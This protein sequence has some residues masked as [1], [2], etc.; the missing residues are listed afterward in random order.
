MVAKRNPF[1]PNSPVSPGMFV[2][3]IDEVLA[4]EQALVQTRAGQPKHFMLTGE[5]G[6]GKTSLLNYLRWV[7]QGDINLES[8]RFR[9][10]V[11]DL[12]IEKGTTPDTFARKIERGLTYELG[13]TE[14]ARDFLKKT[15]NF[16]K[17]VEAYGVSVRDEKSVANPEDI[18]EE[19]A[20][21]LASTVNRICGEPDEDDLFGERYDG[22]LFCI[23][24]ADNASNELQLG[25]VLKLLTER[26]Q[27]RGCERVLIGLAGLQDL[28]EVLRESHPSVLR[29]F[30]EISLQRLSAD[31][32]GKVIDR[33]IDDANLNN[34][35][36]ISIDS[37]AR[38]LLIQ[39]SE[40]YPHF[41][42]QFGYCAFA[43]DT[44]GIIDKDDV[45]RGGFGSRGAL[46]L[47]GDRYYRDDFYNRIQ[48]ESCRQVLR[49]MAD[50]LDEWI[51]KEEIRKR[52]KGQAAT[53]SNALKALRDRHIILSKEGTRGVY[54]LQHKGFGLWIKLYTRDDEVKSELDLPV[55]EA[56][57]KGDG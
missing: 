15:W 57:G 29:V 21:S 55:D 34:I 39:L 33:C 38:Q 6:I 20:Y 52:Y 7:T 48:K 36:K 13:K 11:I 10:L 19:L 32:V 12:D 3:R 37:D 35:E 18:L 42:Q 41:I 43:S 24:E 16:L 44:D 40:G 54:R 9:F 1:R 22:V 23:D 30:D 27:K 28:R 46:E 45:A 4:L 56:T 25:A 2:G 5:R 31:E 51:S 47:I 49:I 50:R 14:K 26:L 17:R 53:L 8:D